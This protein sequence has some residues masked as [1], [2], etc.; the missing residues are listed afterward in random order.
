MVQL[1][2][3]KILFGEYF[4]NPGSQPVHIYASEDEGRTWQCVHVFGRG[5]IRHIHALQEDPYTGC[6]WVCTGDANEHSL[7]AYSEDEGRTFHEIGGGRQLWRVCKLLFTA[8]HVYFGADTNLPEDRWI[9]RWSRATGKVQKLVQ[10]GGPVLDATRLAGGTWVFATDREGTSGLHWFYEADEQDQPTEWD[11]A[12]SLWI[13]PD[14]TGWRRLTISHWLTEARPAFGVP[15]LIGGTPSS[16][17]A[18]TCLN[19]AG[20]NNCVML[21]SEDE[22][23][24]WAL[25]A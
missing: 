16:Q 25:Q 11:D 22:L 24:R 17:L 14:G 19:M 8:D 21:F 20:Y 23:R 9:V 4:S 2:N 6:V 18:I 5:R 12:P 10:V 7:V 15:R 3:G 1:A 13:S